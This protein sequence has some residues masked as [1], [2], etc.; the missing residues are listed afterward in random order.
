M[1]PDEIDAPREP[2]LGQKEDL[3]IAQIEWDLKEHMRIPTDYARERSKEPFWPIGLCVAWALRP[4]VSEAAVLYARHRV[5]LG[6]REVNGWREAQA[7]LLRALVEARIEASGV[8]ADDGKRVPVPALEWID[9]RIVQRGQFDE[10]R[11]QD[12]SIAIVTFVSRPKRLTEYGGPKRLRRPLF[13][14]GGQE[15]RPVCTLSSSG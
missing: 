13:A 8:R 6:I 2:A 3:L 12:G 1:A 7:T 14:S 5:G 11:R 15:R 10:V 4:N 9:L